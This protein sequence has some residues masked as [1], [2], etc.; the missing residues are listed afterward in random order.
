MAIQYDAPTLKG[1]FEEGVLGNPSI[2]P[3]TVRAIN[4]RLDISSETAAEEID[5]AQGTFNSETGAVE[6]TAPP[7]AEDVDALIVD[8]GSSP[9]P[10]G[11]AI[12]FPEGFTEVPVVIFDS[13]VGVEVTFNTI[14]RV[15]QMGNGD[16]DVTV[17]GDQDTTLQGS[18]GN[19]TLTTSGGDDTVVGGRGA[20]SISAGSG[21]DNIRAGSGNDTIISSSG[22]D[23]VDGGS[24]FDNVE[25][26]FAYNPE[27]VVIEGDVI[28]SDGAA[29]SVQLDNVQFVTFSNDHTLTIMDEA[30]QASAMRLYQTILGRAA[31]QPGAEFYLDEALS[32]PDPALVI[33]A[34]MLGSEE[35]LTEHAGLDNQAFVELMYQQGLQREADQAGLEYYV[36]Q[37]D[38]GATRNQ[39]AAEIN[40][41]EES[42]EV[43]SDTVILLDGWV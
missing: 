23:T 27:N 21:N 39:I 20:D 14:D 41:S 29:N 28:F 26:G 32:V 36:N 42:V 19:D 22:A 12:T 17:D 31:D 35:Y 30:D 8:F 18:D 40:A 43:N 7:Q 15:V 1:D 5:V 16:D 38:E 24:G 33:A 34:G 11:T 4:D 10:A 37:L 2:Q 9:P 6:F 3:E 13:D 25:V